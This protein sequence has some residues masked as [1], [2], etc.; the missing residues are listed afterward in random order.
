MEF[1]DRVVIITGGAGGIGKATARV[2]AQNGAKIVLV[3]LKQ[4]ELD[5]A[6]QDLGISQT[7][8]TVAADVSQEAQVIN[9]VDKAW[10][11]YG[12][13]DVF[14]NNAGIE[15]DFALIKDQD[16]NNL[17][18][19]LSV[20]VKG[21]FYGLK[22]IISKMVQQKSGTIVNVSSV[23]GFI[24]SAGLAPYIASKHAVNGLTKTAALECAP[25]GIRVNAVC[26]GP[27]NNRM[28]RAIESGAA[29][30]DPNS[31]KQAFEQQIPLKRYGESHE[32]AD[33]IRFL[34][35]DQAQYITGALYLIDGGMLIT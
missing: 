30:D 35:S 5:Q 22:H 8:I 33:L 13:I 21:V 27:I 29:P 28:M 1:Q 4:Q 15:G 7:C 25:W 18:R 10:T 32:V 17:D 24:G 14:I 9:Y 3:D 31:V 6:V 19:V 23:A 2:F 26:P 20:N 16:S 12:R 34:A 11:A